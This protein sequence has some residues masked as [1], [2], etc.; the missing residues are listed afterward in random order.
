M[1]WQE[2]V[3]VL[4]MATRPIENGKV[5]FNSYN[6]EI[7]IFLY[8]PREHR[9]FNLKSWQMSWLALSASFQYLFHKFMAIINILLFRYGDR[10]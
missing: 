9:V 8:K 3:R 4:I 10:L 5:N 6:A 7:I 2:D 1:I